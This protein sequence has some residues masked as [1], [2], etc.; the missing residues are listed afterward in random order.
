MPY[1]KESK[2]AGTK[3]GGGPHNT[4]Y[5]F[6]GMLAASRAVR[7]KAASKSGGMGIGNVGVGQQNRPV[8]MF[9]AMARGSNRNINR[10]GGGGFGA[11]FKR[12]KSKYAK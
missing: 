6:G 7:N 8:G 11:F 12:K 5:K 10:P 2:R 4:P 1:G 9:G 3:S